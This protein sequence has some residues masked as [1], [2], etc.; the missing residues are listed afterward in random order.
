MAA[1]PTEV[2][3]FTL[4][5]KLLHAAVDAVDVDV[6]P[7]SLP[8]VGQL[9]FRPEIGARNH[10]GTL[11]SGG[12][13][14]VAA[15][16]P[17]TIVVD[18]IPVALAADGSFSVVLVNPKNTA[19]T[20]NGWTWGVEFALTGAKIPS[21]VFEAP[22]G[23]TLDLST[24]TPV[25]ASTG[26]IVVPGPAGPTGAA[27]PVGPEGPYGGTAVTDPAIAAILA[28]PA[29]ATATALNSTF[30]RMVPITAFGAVGDGVADDTAAFNAAITAAN[31][32]LANDR[33]NNTGITIFMPDGRYK[34]TAALDPITVSGVHFLGASRNGTVLLLSSTTTTF[35][36]GMASGVRDVVGGGIRQCKIEY[37][38][39]PVGVCSVATLDRMFGAEF[40]NLILVQIPTLLVCGVSTTRI[41]GGV[42]VRNVAGSMANVGLPLFDLRYGGGFVISDTSAFIRGVLPPVHP[43]AMTTVVGAS[44]FNMTADGGNWDTLLANNCS[45]ERFDIGVNAATGAGSGSVWMDLFFTNVIFDYC[46]NQAIAA[47]ATGGVIA[48]W[49]FVNCWGM[50]WESNSIELQA[51]GIGIND[52][53]TFDMHIPISGKCALYYSV[54]TALRNHFKLEVGINNRL[55]TAAASCH[56]L[57]SST[58][59]NLENSSGNDA[60]TYRADW[61]VVVGSN[62]DH[63]RISNN[64]LTGTNGGYNFFAANSAGSLNRVFTGNLG[65]H[66]DAAMPALAASAAENT[67]K[68]GHIWEVQIYGGTVT[69]ITKNGVA[70]T[71]MTA[72]MLRVEPGESFA[73][74][75]S[76]A[77]SVTRF[78][79]A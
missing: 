14:T 25:D 65:T 61:G 52:G 49:R 54:P 74:T 3:T 36:W 34:I 46:K 35:T 44:V 78:L 22:T 31:L 72:G 32:S 26:A 20:P 53:H 63:Y 67:N 24:V 70:I 2:T 27:G 48:N 64:R 11:R 5:G 51:T 39:D 76:V 60:D 75:Y 59:F 15:T 77:P 1:L 50:S 56:F 47:I 38:N 41:S 66:Y 45:F 7:D 71:G 40:E 43:A 16:P 6:L 29:S 17:V 69:A 73:V 68:T 37:L 19:L 30:A 58:G 12:R 23:A 42:T 79:M 57:A 62:C 18:P 4:S 33:E 10:D 9:T 13:V 55:G 8:M 21:F 28:T